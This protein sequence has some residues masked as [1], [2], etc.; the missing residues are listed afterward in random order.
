MSIDFATRFTA[1]TLGL[2]LLTAGCSGSPPDSDQPSGSAA[3]VAA[4]APDFDADGIADVVAGVG[5]SPARATVVYGSGR[6]QDLRRADLDGIDSASF[7]A[8]LLARD[9]DGDGHT[10]LVIGD[11]G[12]AVAAAVFVVP[13]SS[14]GLDPTRA[15][16]LPAPAGVAAFGAALAVADAPQRT[17]AV[18]APGDADGA[19]G[20]AVAL[21]SLGADGSPSGDPRIVTQ[22]SLGVAAGKAGDQFGVTLAATGG[23]LAIGAPRSDT[24]GVRDSGSVVVIDLTASLQRSWLLAQGAEAVPGTAQAEDRFGFALTAAD[25]WLAVGVPMDDEDGRDAGLV[26]PFRL[27]AEGPVAE[28]QLL[29]GDLGTGD[30]AGRLFGL[31]LAMARPC[32]GTTGLVIGAPGTTVGGTNAAGAAW[33][34]ALGDAD[35]T[36]RELVEGGVLGGTATE[37]ASLGRAVSMLTGPG[38]GPDTVVL[39]APGNAEEAIPGRVLT[40]AAPF[41]GPAQI[42]LDGLRLAEEGVLTLASTG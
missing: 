4:V 14:S 31:S 27:T 39:A 3:P 25:G 16:T 26:Q 41:A 20:G 34:I 7:A 10:D 18:G 2:V 32:A 15:R 37:M 17:L 12:P 9:L 13:G 40:L 28:D 19:V 35:C 23:W 6:T 1:L 5:E 33:L 42:E 29:P 38:S 21:W 36:P 11:P 8:A 30:P 22:E 24:G